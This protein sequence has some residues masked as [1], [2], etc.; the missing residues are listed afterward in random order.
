MPKSYIYLRVSSEG[1]KKSGLGEE[2]QHTGA[3][4]LYESTCKPLSY[5]PPVIFADLAVSAAAF[6]FD[7]R[8][9]AQRLL[10]ALNRDDCVIFPKLDRGFRN[11]TDMLVQLQSWDQQGVR[12]FSPEFAGMPYDSKS[13]AGRI[14][15]VMAGL[16]AE[17][18][19]RRLK[20]RM[21][22]VLEVQKAEGRPTNGYAPWGFRIVP[23][24]DG[25]FLHPDDEERFWMRY[26][27]AAIEKGYT[28][29]G[30]TELMYQQGFRNRKKQKATLRPIQLL[31]EAEQ[32][33]RV[34]EEKAGLDWRSN[35]YVTPQGVIL[36]RRW[37]LPD[38]YK[39]P[40][41]AGNAE[42]S[43]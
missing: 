13:Y 9:E 21:A 1:Q 39:Q 18:E 7:K 27:V 35:T 29:R 22:G 15:A 10:L 34:M 2:A 28:Q 6:D 17:W 11:L 38:K 40:I 16:M 14:I 3:L 42:Q 24:D 20:E 37:L 5:D 31:L 33:L 23:S 8:P 4:A 12:V 19:T 43:A 26:A 41:G 36:K 25:K 32:R 30:L